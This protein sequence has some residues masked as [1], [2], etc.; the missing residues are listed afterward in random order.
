MT[1][2]YCLA[3]HIRT[4]EPRA[5]EHWPT[6]DALDYDAER[7]EAKR[8]IDLAL[9]RQGIDPA[10]VSDP[11][12]YLR[13]AEVYC[14]LADLCWRSRV[15]GGLDADNWRS[16]WQHY[17]T[18]YEAELAHP[19]NLTLEDDDVDAPSFLPRIRLRRA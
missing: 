13:D 11:T 5:S 7:V 16:D 15:K 3:A 8:K 4:V 2:T 12:T 6:E 19:H 17:A 9:E 1:V 18:S 14:V 10:Y